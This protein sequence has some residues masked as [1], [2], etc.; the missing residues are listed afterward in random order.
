MDGG[1]RCALD[2]A[3]YHNCAPCPSSSPCLPS[4]PRS[5]HL[6][7]GL[8]GLSIQWG[9]WAEGGMAAGNAATAKAVERLGM[10][11]I[12]PDQ[13]VGAIQALMLLHGIA[14]L[15]A[16]TAVV[17]FR[18]VRFIQR[19]GGGPLPPMF[20]AFEA[21]A[22]A[23]TAKEQ[24][25]ARAGPAALPAAIEEA[26]GDADVK[27]SRHRRSSPRRRI[28]A[29]S[30]RPVKI[31]AAAAAG[32]AASD[33]AAS[34][35]YMVAQVQEAVAS[36]LGS[37]V[38]LDDP[39]MAAGL[40]SLGSGRVLHT[41]LLCC[42]S[43]R[44]AFWAE[45]RVESGWPCQFGGEQILAMPLS[46]PCPAVELR[47]A[48]EKQAGV[49]LPSTL[50]FDYPTISA[51]AGFMAGKVALSQQH[52]ELAAAGY[53]VDWASEDEG[54]LGSL[55]LM[56]ADVAPQLRLVGA[57]ELAVR[58]AGDAMLCPQPCDQSIPIPVERW[59]VE[60]QAELVSGTPVQASCTW[61]CKVHVACLLARALSTCSLH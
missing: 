11:M 16:V 40:D 38:G 8:G 59:D 58:S 27:S 21:E 44:S 51:L 42:R 33:A 20:A 28:A 45:S 7:Q 30:R 18:W 31:A 55:E 34:K 29:A 9:A 53:E 12:A 22:A 32:T 35:E 39:L 19:L 14:A 54:S 43:H 2:R 46:L 15:P 13:G 56:P 26:A 48:L 41:G 50:V 24:T 4:I 60:A 36:V 47:N 5:T 61:N 10:R 17:P 25:A 3:H 49:E 57:S 6:V 52:A 1:N 23:D 37:A